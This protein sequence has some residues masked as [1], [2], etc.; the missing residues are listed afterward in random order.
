MECTGDAY[1]VLEVRRHSR[2][3]RVRAAVAQAHRA[4]LGPLGGPCADRRGGALVPPRT[5]VGWLT[6][7]RRHGPAPSLRGCN[8]TPDADA[9]AN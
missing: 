2:P 5:S 8:R 6:G 9:Y 3:R 1:A 4:A 7:W